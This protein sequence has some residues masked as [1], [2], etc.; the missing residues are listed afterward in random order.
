MTN[1]TSRNALAR[2][3][4]SVLVSGETGVFGHR[5]YS[6][7][8]V[9]R[10]VAVARRPEGQVPA[11]EAEGDACLTRSGQEWKARHYPLAL[12]LAECGERIH[13]HRA[14]AD[15]EGARSDLARAHVIHGHALANLKRL[16]E[17][18]GAYEEALSI[19]RDLVAA[20]RAD[21]REN[22]ATAQMNRG[23]ALA[24]LKRLD[25]G[26]GGV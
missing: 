3:A 4:A 17:A 10:E 18:V 1:G 11:G 12:A 7:H 13:R 9:A 24:N 6:L 5:W 14:M 26:G 19:W 21:L 15:G 23:N 8:A 20:G 22:V 2:L 16:E 25:G